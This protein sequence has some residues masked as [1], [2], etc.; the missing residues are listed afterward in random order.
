MYP[1]F[2][3]IKP[4]HSA[5]NSSNHSC[6]EWTTVDPYLH[7][8]REILSSPASNVRSK[9]ALD[10]LQE[11]RDGGG[12]S[13]DNG[14]GNDGGVNCKCLGRLQIQHMSYHDIILKWRDCELWSL[15]AH[16][17]ASSEIKSTDLRIALVSPVVLVT[18]QTQPDGPERKPS[19]TLEPRRLKPSF[20][21]DRLDC[22]MSLGL[23]ADWWVSQTS[24]QLW[25]EGATVKKK[26]ES[27][28]I[29]QK[30]YFLTIYIHMTSLGEKV[31]KPLVLYNPYLGP[32]P[33]FWAKLWASGPLVVQ[34]DACHVS[35][36]VSSTKSN[37]WK[38][39][40]FGHIQNPAKRKYGPVSFLH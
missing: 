26:K 12:G 28:S 2:L 20:W 5:G 30:Q 35:W 7:F 40:R 3:G 23:G 14:G 18:L 19:W 16:V 11:R 33:L 38:S 15:D 36:K 21:V 9:E 17:S 39:L 13:D 29:N 6:W 25:F 10:S 22:A 34:R 24:S 31:H 8:A 32:S 27:I 4:N 1:R 37:H